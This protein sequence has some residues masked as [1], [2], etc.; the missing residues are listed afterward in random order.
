[1]TAVIFAGPSLRAEDRARFPGL[2]FLPPLALGPIAE[3]LTQG[4]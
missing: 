1:M 4:R 2:T 3:Q